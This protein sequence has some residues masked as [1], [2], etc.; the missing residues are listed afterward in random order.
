MRNV[1]V[2]THLFDRVDNVVGKFL[3]RVIGRRVESCFRSVVIDRHTTADVQ[4]IDRRFQLVNLRV[5]ASRFLHRILDALDVGE[6][7]TDMEVKELQHVHAI[8]FLQTADHLQKLGSSQTKLRGLATGFFPATGAF[9]VELHAHAEHRQRA[10]VTLDDVENVIQLVE[11][12]DHDHDPLSDSR[13]GKC[14]F[15]E[16]FVLKAV[17]DEQAVAR[18]FERERGV[19]LGFRTRFESEIVA[20]TFAEIFL[21][22][23]TLLVH[24]HRVNT[25]V[26]ALVLILANR[27]AKRALKFSY[28][29]CD[30]LRKAQQHGR[31]DTTFGKVVYDLSEVRGTWISLDRANDKVS[32]AVNIKVASTPVFDSISFERL[33]DCRGQ[34]AV[35]CLRNKTCTI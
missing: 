1:L 35:S 6:L 21:D 7:R 11:L 5:H 24:L 18:L 22:D 19:K 12:L 14:Q 2:I 13:T 25:H 4:K 9:R 20:G 30:E 34:L 32:L 33:L 26:R 27:A 10:F 17:E 31:G 23:A 28:L 15:D 3:C 16:L 8:G 29:S